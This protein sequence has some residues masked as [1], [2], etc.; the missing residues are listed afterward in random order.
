M[1][2]LNIGVVQVAS[3]MEPGDG[4]KTKET[5]L[6]TIF[7]YI[8]KLVF[9]N[10]TVDMIVFPELFLNGYDS[11]IW[12]E[13]AESIP[14]GPTIQALCNKAKE[15]QKWIVPG[16][17]VERGDDGKMYNTTLLISPMGEIKLK[18]R[19]VFIP[20]PLEVSTPGNEFPV[21][22]IP[23]VGKVGFVICADGHYPESIRNLVMKGAEL[24]IK[25]TL[26]GE[27]IGGLRNHTPIAITRAVENQ[28]YV[29]SVNQAGPAG[30]GNTVAVD[31]EG[32][33]IEELNIQ[34]SFTFIYVDFEEVRRVRETGA[35]GMFGFL[36]MLKEFKEDGCNV[37]ECYA[38]DISQAPVY[39]NLT[40]PHPKHPTDIIRYDLKKP[41]NV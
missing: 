32:R 33:I 16:S 19:K 4:A 15:V 39:N 23:G 14:N 12:D 17:L 38:N 1:S 34:E 10:P 29:I 24:I 6:Q 35:F 18:Y 36:K 26:Q 31:P 21:F 22:E 11:T 20:Y 8:D 28:C 13:M 5:N 27:W 7:S 30:M 40:F 9:M 37:D 2:S 3:F 41:A 25:P